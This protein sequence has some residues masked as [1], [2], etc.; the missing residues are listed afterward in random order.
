MLFELI[1][2]PFTLLW[3]TVAA[4]GAL[5]FPFMIGISAAFGVLFYMLFLVQDSDEEHIP[6]GFISTG[7]LTGIIAVMWYTGAGGPLWAYLS[8]H[9]LAA[10]V[11]LVIWLV[12]G[13][14]WSVFKLDRLG[15]RYVELH[16]KE[17]LRVQT[18]MLDAL[19]NVPDS[20]NDSVQYSGG[21]RDEAHHVNLGANIKGFHAK[22]VAW[23][24]D[25]D[26]RAAAIA[27]LESGTVPDH[28]QLVE[29][30]K[31]HMQRHL[32]LSPHAVDNKARIA[33]WILWWPGSMVT[34]ALLDMVRDLL[35]KY[36]QYFGH[37]YERVMLRHTGTLDARFVPDPKR[38]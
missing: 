5:S 21:N 29:G 16:K 1:L 20:L 24:A 13:M 38:K 4:V 11:W 30:V 14:F 6:S 19:K 35:K 27:Q 26:Q 2:F 28:N 17:L 15:A 22:D 36:W 23:V 8:A 31:E 34:Y 32:Q 25:P 33:A 10:L 18:K 3:L 12:V 37:L 7:I 9:W